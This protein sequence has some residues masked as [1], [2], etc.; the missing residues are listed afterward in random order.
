MLRFCKAVHRQARP[1]RSR[2]QFPGQSEQPP[3]SFAVEESTKPRRHKLTAGMA[4]GMLGAAIAN[5]FDLLK[6]RLQAPSATSK[7]IATHWREIV[8]ASGYKGLYRAVWPTTIRAGI[9]TSS[10]LASYD[11]TKHIILG[12]KGFEEG[13]K[14]HLMASAVAGVVCS[15]A[16]APVDTV[17]VRESTPIRQRPT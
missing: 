4:S 8:T 16:S 10:Q 5:P 6:I 14:T 13:F 2:E 9:L 17:K 11:E 3:F 1:E 7:S 15:L 12:L